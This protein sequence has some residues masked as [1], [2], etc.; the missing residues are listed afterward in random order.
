MTI[1]FKTLGL[2]LIYIPMC[3]VHYR[4]Y[5]ICMVVICSVKATFCVS[6]IYVCMYVYVHSGGVE[7]VV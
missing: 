2:R 6:F 3:F 7:R 5:T 4:A 1:R